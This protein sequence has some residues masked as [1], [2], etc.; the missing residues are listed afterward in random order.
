MKNIRF[1]FCLLAVMMCLDMALAQSQGADTLDGRVVPPLPQIDAN[2]IR[3]AYESVLDRDTIL[4][5]DQI[6]WRFPIPESYW[7]RDTLLTFPQV[8]NPLIEGVEA[9]SPITMDAQHIKKRK[10]AVEASIRLTSFDSGDYA[11]PYMPLYV[12]RLNGG[13]DTLWFKGPLLNVKTFPIDTASYTAFDIK[14]Q[15]IYPITAGE[16]FMC[17]GIV[18]G[19][20]ALVWLIVW[21]VRRRKKNLPFFGPPKPKEPAHVVA[22]RSLDKIKQQELWKA[23]KIKA[24]YTQLTDTLRVYLCD[25]WGIQAMEQTSA[26]MLGALQQEH[27]A[28]E[29]LQEISEML[30]VSD[31]AKF[32]KYVPSDDENVGALQQAVRFVTATARYEETPDNNNA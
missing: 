20:V 7:D 32:A 10:A 24:Y 15:M 11:L 2:G 12:K 21:L 1:L 22:L 16:V 18:L 25:R 27:L 13:V 6:L 26:E 31:L 28:K 9:L 5:G 8:P 23:H 3:S 14:P 30:T 29:T 4:I 19:V 17:L